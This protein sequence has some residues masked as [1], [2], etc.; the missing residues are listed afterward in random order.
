MRVLITGGAGYLGGVLTDILLRSDHQIA[1]VLGSNV[2]CQVWDENEQGNIAKSLV[3]KN[4]R[5]ESPRMYFLA[6]F[7]K[8]DIEKINGWDEEFM[9]GYACEDYDFGARWNRAGIP[10]EVREDIQGCHQYHPRQE[11]VSGGWALNRQ[12]L[13]ENN[14][15]GIIRCQN[16]LDNLRSRECLN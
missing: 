9:K 7:N 13:R 3:N 2:I 15:L 8:T 12:R 11:T 4:Y 5:G 1:Q 10:F 6:M 16:G 14:R